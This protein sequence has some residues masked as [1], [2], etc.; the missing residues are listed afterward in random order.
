MEFDLSKLIAEST[1]AIAPQQTNSVHTANELGLKADPNF[2]TVSLDEVIAD[3]NKS[4]MTLTVPEDA[5]Q[6]EDEEEARLE[7]EQE[8]D[9][10]PPQPDSTADENCAHLCDCSKWWS[11]GLKQKCRYPDLLKQGLCP[12]CLDCGASTKVSYTLEEDFKPGKNGNDQLSPRAQV[13]IRNAHTVRIKDMSIEQLT[14]HIKHLHFQIEELRVQAMQ[15][16]HRR[17]ELEEEEIANIPESERKA[18]IE[19]LRAGKEAKKKVAKDAK[20]AKPKKP[21]KAAI[22]EAAESKEKALVV[23]IQAQGKS[24]QDAKVIASL[25]TRTGKSQAQVEALLND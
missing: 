4:D 25:M 5:N 6:S 17:T 23:T 22:A 16:R 18:F 2:T 12:E 8:A 10:L 1:G 15:S 9:V 13:I 24:L 14:F 11:H 19:A 20:E 7:E 3:L 21:T